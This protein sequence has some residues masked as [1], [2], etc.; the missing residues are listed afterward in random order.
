MKDASL[1]GP[2]GE[3]TGCPATSAEI[4]GDRQSCEFSR[5]CWEFRTHR[6]KSGDC[7]NCRNISSDGKPGV[8]HL[9][10][11][12]RTDTVG[13]CSEQTG[14]GPTVTFF[15]PESTCGDAAVCTTDYVQNACKAPR[16][17]VPPGG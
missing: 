1:I 3:F 2:D 4:P 14:G 5:F 10:G 16:T 12:W 8:Y 9:G 13:G 15:Y 11:C 17:Y 7:L 6:T